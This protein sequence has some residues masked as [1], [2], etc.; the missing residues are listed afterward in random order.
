MPR[1]HTSARS[2][3]ISKCLRENPLF[4]SLSAGEL[5]RLAASFSEEE[6]AAGEEIFSAGDVAGALYVVLEG[7]VTIHD[8]ARDEAQRARARLVRGNFFGEMDLLEG[9]RRQETARAAEPGVVLRV[10]RDD[11]LSFLDEHSVIALKLEM[12]AARGHSTRAAA[13]LAAAERRTTRTRVNQEA[14]LKTGAGP[15]RPVQLIDL[16]IAGLCMAGAPADWQPDQ[17]VSFHLVWTDRILR[18]YGRIA[19]R[20]QETVGVELL[21]RTPESDAW[22]QRV[23]ARM[24][25][26]NGDGTVPA[27][28]SP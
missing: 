17:R 20:S 15:S 3:R 25:D 11:L 21:D 9:G 8:P 13:A 12:A 22:I 18:F 10:S 28:L 27:A 4:Q 5:D 16:S 14:A 19:W 6:V 24:M 2:L 7:T 23:L 1:E 26:T